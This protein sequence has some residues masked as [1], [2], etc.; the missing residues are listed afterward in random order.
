M[1]RFSLPRSAP[2]V[3]AQ[4]QNLPLRERFHVIARA[5]SAPLDA[6]AARVPSGRIAEVGCGHGLLSAMIALRDPDTKV[7][8]SDPDERKM[9]WANQGPGRLPNVEF[10]PG[11][12]KELLDL[13]RGSFDA[14]VVSDVL[15]LFPFDRWPE[16]LEDLRQLLRPGG[17]LV[18]KEVEGDRSWRHRK[19]IVQEMVMTRALGLTKHTGVAVLLPR[20][21]FGPILEKAGFDSMETYDLARGYTTPHILYTARRAA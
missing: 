1:K 9:T 19:A 13:H 6:V 16:F 15:Y 2:E 3:Y 14:V 17:L 12:A 20:K 8:G 10:Y 7:I 5:S 18:L 21:E 11:S 4:F